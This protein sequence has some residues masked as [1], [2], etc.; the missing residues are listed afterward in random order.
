MGFLI[1]HG[2][3]HDLPFAGHDERAFFRGLGLCECSWWQSKFATDVSGGQIFNLCFGANLWSNLQ[4]LRKLK[5][6]TQE[7]VSVEG[8]FSQI[9]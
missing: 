1:F 9:N 2:A 3:G 4:S 8:M 5:L 7:L 6:R